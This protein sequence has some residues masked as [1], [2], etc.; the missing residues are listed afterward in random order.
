MSW[1][2]TDDVE[3]YAERAWELLAARPAEN[4]VALTVVESLRAGQRW[5][6]EPMLFGWYEAERVSGA[7]SMTP[8]Y[9][10]LLA[11]VPDGA[12]DDL[13]AA[14]RSRSVPV[15]GVSGD[16][17]TV[18]RFTRVWTAGSAPLAATTMHMRLYVLGTL[19]PPM[20]PAT[21]RARP[22]GAADVD[23]MAG[24]FTDFQRE[25]GVPAVDVEP[26]VRDRVRN[27]LLWLWEDDAGSPVSLA[28]RNRS[29]AGVARVGPV[30]T[31]PQHRRLGYGAAVTAACTGDALERGADTVVLFTDLANPTSNSI[32]QQIG[33]RPVRDHKVVHFPA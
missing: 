8:P 24:W 21:G 11:A 9:E 32:Y 5:S 18:D 19:R 3:V 13:V 25:V 7:V 17:P 15:N 10:L 16:P 26:I 6:T 27:G 22:A 1:S 28:G 2:F 30:Y 12:T 4:T 20:P 23:A 33:F 14:L 29:A 31:P